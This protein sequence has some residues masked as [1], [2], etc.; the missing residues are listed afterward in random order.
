V[1][2]CGSEDFSAKKLQ[3]YFDILKGFVGKIHEDEGRCSYACV[4][5]GGI[6]VTRDYKKY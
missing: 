1:F 3:K 6:Y 5:R 2:L 4:A